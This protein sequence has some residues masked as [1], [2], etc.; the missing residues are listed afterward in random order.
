M[1]ALKLGSKPGP[2]WGW[3]GAGVLSELGQAAVGAYGQV[4]LWVQSPV[5][6]KFREGLRMLILSVI[7]RQC[8][9][10]NSDGQD[11]TFYK[12]ILSNAQT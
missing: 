3:G 7:Q 8:K 6:E 1:I 12:A 2:V 9:D 11:L 4:S 10:L 5:A